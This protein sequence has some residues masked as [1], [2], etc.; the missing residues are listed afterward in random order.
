MWRKTEKNSARVEYVT[1]C[2][3]RRSR[4]ASGSMKKKKTEWARGPDRR[5]KKKSEKKLS[6]FVRK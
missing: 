4:R 5:Q 1:G 3:D 2:Q 6:D